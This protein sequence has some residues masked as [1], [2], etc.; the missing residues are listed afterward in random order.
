PYDNGSTQAAAARQAVL[1]V[2]AQRQK[3]NVIS[4]N[5]QLWSPNEAVKD[6]AAKLCSGGACGK[7]PQLLFAETVNFGCRRLNIVESIL[8]CPCDVTGTDTYSYL[9]S[10]GPRR[11][12]Q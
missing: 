10:V 1:H 5:L 4:H 9:L 3:G 7:I 2:F 8:C 12:N 11:H 6:L